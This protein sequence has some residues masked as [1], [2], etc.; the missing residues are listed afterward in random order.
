MPTFLLRC[1]NTTADSSGGRHNGVPSFVTYTTDRAGVSR[2]ACRFKTGAGHATLQALPGASNFAFSLWVRLDSLPATLCA[3]DADGARLFSN[4]DGST[5]AGTF[6]LT[7]LPS[8]ELRVITHDTVT[9][10]LTA[11]APFPLGLWQHVAVVHEGASLSLFQDGVVVAT[12]T[13]NAGYA[14]GNA[15]LNT[16]P[17]IPSCGLP[18]AMDEVRLDSRALLDGEVLSLSL[19]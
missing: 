8:G 14:A 10:R 13:S 1:E 17:A 6:E 9:R 5:A 3:G 16:S 19:E 12:G 7:V 2:L 11:P 15:E 18:V 4:E